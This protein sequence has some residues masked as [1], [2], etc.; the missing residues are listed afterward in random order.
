MI[1]LVLCSMVIISVRVVHGIDKSPEAVE[2]WIQ[3]LSHKKEKLTKLHFFL[4]DT[5]SGKNP[6][7][8]KVA[9]SNITF[10]SPTL[11]GLITMIDDPLT[12]GPELNSSKV[13]RA[14]GFY[15]FSS[16]EESSLVMTMNF[17]FTNGK[18]NGSTLS[19]LGRNPLLNRYRE[20]SIVGGSGVFR[21]ARGIATSQTTWLN[22][23]TGDAIIEY[24]VIAIHY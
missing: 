22:M 20:L 21:L 4:H 16:L 12:V 23:T 18:Y 1:V 17:F 10:T 2:K 8:L 15:G 6:T 14:Q 24:N 13:G 5:V 3:K 7:A 11:F 19:V 9:Q